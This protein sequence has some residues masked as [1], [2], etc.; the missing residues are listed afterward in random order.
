MHDHQHRTQRERQDRN[1]LLTILEGL[2]FDL[3]RFQL[4]RS[5]LSEYLAVRV[6]LLCGNVLSG[7]EE[8]SESSELSFDVSDRARS[9]GGRYA[10]RLGL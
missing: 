1:E 5:G 2:V 4:L 9:G 10:Q 3:K 6:R 7:E 8:Q